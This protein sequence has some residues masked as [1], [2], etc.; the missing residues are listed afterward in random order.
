MKKLNFIT[1]FNIDF[2]LPFTALRNVREKDIFFH[3]TF[4]NFEN[5]EMVLHLFV[6]GSIIS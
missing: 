3:S 4:L 6:A 1:R 2:L 5:I